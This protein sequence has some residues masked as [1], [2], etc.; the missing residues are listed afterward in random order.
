VEDVS[1]LDWEMYSEAEAASLLGVAPSTF[2]Y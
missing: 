2:N 1:V